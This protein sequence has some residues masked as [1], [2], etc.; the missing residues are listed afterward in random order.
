MRRQPVDG[1]QVLDLAK[2]RISRQQR[3]LP[4]LGQSHG[5]RIGIGNG[6]MGF[7]VSSRQGEFPIGLD[8]QHWP[9]I[10]YRNSLLSCR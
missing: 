4:G 5:K 3:S 9:L 6:M 10:D 7:D 1:H 2:L 8:D